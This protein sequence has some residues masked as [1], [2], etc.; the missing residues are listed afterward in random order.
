VLSDRSTSDLVRYRILEPLRQYAIEKL[1]ET[2]EADTN[3]AKHLNYFVA[4]T[5]RAYKERIVNESLWLDH[6]EREHDN[7]RA[8]LTWA[9]HH[10]PATALKLAGGLAWF[11]A[12]HSHFSEGRRWLRHV[13]TGERIRNRETA[14]AL[15]GATS[16]AAFQGDH[17]EHE[18]AEEGLA[19]WRELDEKREIAL[20]LESRGWHL[21]SGGN[22]EDSKKSFEEALQ[23]LSELN[24]EL[25]MNR[26]RIGICQVLVSEF[27]V[28]RAE[29]MAH[30]CLSIALK[31]DNPRDIHFAHHFLADCALI[32]GDVENSL[33]KYADSLRA[34]VRINDRLETTFEI[35]GMA[36]SLA[37]MGQGEKALRLQGA[38]EAERDALRSNVS[39]DFWN[40][41][42]ERYIG[43]AE[44]RLG[45]EAT[46]AE[47]Q[48]GRSMT[49]EAA[50][51]YALR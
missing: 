51:E 15:C 31:Y 38:I 13:L 1:T 43:A 49:L 37:G 16:L 48:I 12:L 34:A 24:D 14:R 8:A 44:K 29:P 9:S 4:L 27:D 19:I 45:P 6:L 36:M 35:Q 39:I 3:A 17:M 30:Q 41:L 25:G 28:E 46:A 50:I 40:Q 47:K 23:I 7:L 33:M 10:D 22:S 11:W 20:A 26:I 42:I 21:W 2:G 32:R 5:E 18:P